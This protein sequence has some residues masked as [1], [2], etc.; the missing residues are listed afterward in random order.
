[1]F[2]MFFMFLSKDDIMRNPF[3]RSTGMLPEVFIGRDREMKELKLSFENT[4]INRAEQTIMYGSFGIGKTS[5]LI[6]FKNEIKSIA[7]V[8][9]IPLYVTDNITE[10]CDLILREA[11]SQLHLKSAKLRKRLSNLGFSFLGISASITLADV[12]KNLEV[13][14]FN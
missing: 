11:R 8:I 2:Y 9:R 10:I 4:K 13:C 7:N 1:M 12:Q 14:L 6:K 5:I 3:M